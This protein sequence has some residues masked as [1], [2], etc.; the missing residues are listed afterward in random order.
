MKDVKYVILYD[1]SI[2]A[3]PTLWGVPPPVWIQTEEPEVFQFPDVAIY[4]SFFHS[5]SRHKLSGCNTRILSHEIKHLLLKGCQGCR[6]IV[7]FSAE[8]SVARGKFRGKFRLKWNSISFKPYK[9][10][11]NKDIMSERKMLD[12]LHKNFDNAL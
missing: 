1:V 10:L 9:M 6:S 8:N 4:R 5:C 3:S 11:N 2:G 12:R 7:I